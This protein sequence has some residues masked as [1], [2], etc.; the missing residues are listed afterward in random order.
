MR[1]LMGLLEPARYTLSVATMED[2]E[3]ITGRAGFGMGLFSFTFDMTRQTSPPPVDPAPV[4]EP[5]SLLLL[6]T[7]LAG[8]LRWRT[9]R[10]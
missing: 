7:G 1:S 6:G 8:V 2:A 4:P 9:R 3:Q 5:A 10:S